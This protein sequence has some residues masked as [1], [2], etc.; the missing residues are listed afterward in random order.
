MMSRFAASQSV[1]LDLPGSRT[2][3]QAYL[4]QPRRLVYALFASDR[5]KECGND[6]FR[7]RMQALQFFMLKIQPTVDLRV[8]TDA[9]SILHIEAVDCQ[10]SGVDAINRQFTL[11][12]TGQLYAAAERVVTAEPVDLHDAA[13]SS[14]LTG[15]A[16]LEVRVDLPPSF[17][18]I[19]NAIVR[20]VGNRLLSGVLGTIEERLINHL[21]QDYG[22]WSA[23]QTAH[24]V[25]PQNS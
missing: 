11:T 15:I 22:Q 3:L 10:I 13:E 1:E 12:L 24:A 6:V 16:D 4:A 23:A 18:I 14:H 8:W 9:G 25:T 17:A 7:L 20:R 21:R 19:S 2:A 5:V